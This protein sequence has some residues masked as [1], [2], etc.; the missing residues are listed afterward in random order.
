MID[1]PAPLR[2]AI[3]A[4]ARLRDAIEPLDTQLYSTPLPNHA[5]IGEHVRHCLDHV[6]CFLKGYASGHVDYDARTRDPEV[7]RSS[8]LARTNISEYIEALTRVDGGALDEPLAVCHTCAPGGE[9]VV[10]HSTTARELAFLSS[11]TVHHVALVGLIAESLGASTDPNLAL[12]F[13]T[14]AH[15]RASE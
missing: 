6:D 8:E 13:S 5:A 10:T 3:D 4:L 7:E 11:H 2:G 12:A 14:E 15:R 1:L 9:P